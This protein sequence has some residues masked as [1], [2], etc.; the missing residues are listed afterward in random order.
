MLSGE[1][2]MRVL[3]L[4]S[5]VVALLFWGYSV[6]DM[7]ASL[8][9]WPPYVEQ[10]G[11]DMFAWIQGFPLWRKIVWGAGIACG[12]G[13]A[14]LMFARTK[15]A[16]DFMLAAVGF[17]VLGFAYDLVFED[18][19]LNYGQQGLVAS[20]VIIAIASFFTWAAYAS[21]RRPTVALT[22]PAA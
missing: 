22:E 2:K 20:A 12:L 17:T 18:G 21:A 7:W 16:G 5:A 4:V 6:F 13:G 10:Y 3:G 1:G 11:A 14:A 9:S 15:I 8:T 19:V